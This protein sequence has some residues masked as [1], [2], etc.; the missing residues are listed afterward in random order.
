MKIIETLEDQLYVMDRR[1]EYKGYIGDVIYDGYTGTLHSGVINT[2]SYSVAIT[3]AY[4][5]ETL[6]KHF[7]IAVDMYLESCEEDGVPP[8]PPGEINEDRYQPI[9]IP[10]WLQELIAEPQPAESAAVSAKTG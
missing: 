7:A 8:A 10:E 2:G 6:E 5:I 1:L 4:D 9:V 3:E